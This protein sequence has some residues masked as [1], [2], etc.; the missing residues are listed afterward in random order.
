V[1]S[2]H[3]SDRFFTTRL[4]WI[5][6]FYT[7]LCRRLKE[8]RRFVQGL[9]S[10]PN[11]EVDF[12]ISRGDTLVAIEVKSGRRRMALPGV[13]EFSRQFDVRKTLLVGGDGIPLD[14][15]LATRPESW[16]KI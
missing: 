4:R 11:R 8:P 2:G 1:V 3:F 5:R 7:A 14:E 9:R 10:A 6:S 16:L 12:V 15:F 13:A